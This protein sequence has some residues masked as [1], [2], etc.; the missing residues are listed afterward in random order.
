MHTFSVSFLE[1]KVKTQKGPKERNHVKVKEEDDLTK[2]QRSR[3][4]LAVPPIWSQTF[5]SWWQKN[6]FFFKSKP[7]SPQSFVMAVL[8][9]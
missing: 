3:E 1:E 9:N 6:A 5:R 4:G 7:F 2:G 8:E